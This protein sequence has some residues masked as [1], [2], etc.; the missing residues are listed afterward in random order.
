MTYVKGWG[1]G[2]EK[3]VGWCVTTIQR[4]SLITYEVFQRERWFILCSRWESGP[5]NKC[6]Q[7][8]T[9]IRLVW[10]IPPLVSMSI[11]VFA[12]LGISS[13]IGIMVSLQ[14]IVSIFVP[15]LLLLLLHL[16]QVNAFLVH[17][18]EID[19]W[20]SNCYWALVSNNMYISPLVHFAL[21]QR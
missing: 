10:L 14:M 18:S 16:I 7:R 20:W 8:C 15:E 9:F 2:N 11:L 4:M 19:G 21:F 13:P 3:W 12:T 5:L 1:I 6:D 17:V